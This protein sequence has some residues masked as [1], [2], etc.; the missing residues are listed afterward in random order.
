MMLSMASIA[1][2]RI[3][4]GALAD[5]PPNLNTPQAKATGRDRKVRFVSTSRI[6]SP[7]TIRFKKAKYKPTM[8]EDNYRKIIGSPDPV[9]L[10]AVD[11]GRV[12]PDASNASIAP[13]SPNMG[14]RRDKSISKS[15]SP[16]LTPT[17]PPVAK[18]GGEQL[19]TI[20]ESGVTHALSDCPVTP[21]FVTPKVRS[22]P[23]FEGFQI[24]QPK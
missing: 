13:P 8:V 23:H 16:A 1:A 20:S 17:T 6:T 2:P 10:L 24:F 22:F 4:V 12:T 7:S 21:E 3:R 9:A 19:I 14:K 15:R 5:L 18:F 11:S